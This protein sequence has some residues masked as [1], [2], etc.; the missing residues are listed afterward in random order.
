M[1]HAT[2]VEIAKKVSINRT[3]TYDVLDALT[4]K[5]LVSKYKKESKTYFNA[6]SPERLL[7]YLDREKEEFAVRVERKK[8]K[9]A[10]VMPALISMQNF[11][12]KTKPKVQFFEGVKGIREAYEDTLTADGLIYGY[13]NVEEMHKTLPDFFPKYYERRMKAGIHIKAMLTQDEFSKERAKHDAEEARTTRFLPEHISFVPEIDIYNNKVLITS[14][15]EKMAI[16]IESK[17]LTDFH[18]RIYDYIWDTLE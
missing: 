8:A 14:W 1:G 4:Q 17:E 2:A 11:E 13:A 18:R 9:I 10:E 5:G 3:T 16:L 7:T 6:L 15:R 12:S